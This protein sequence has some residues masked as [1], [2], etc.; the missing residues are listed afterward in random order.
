M[1]A[2][3]CFGSI[4]R[5]KKKPLSDVSRPYSENRFGSACFNWCHFVWNREHTLRKNRLAVPLSK[6][7][8]QFGHRTAPV[9]ITAEALLRSGFHA[10]VGGCTRCTYTP[11]PYKGSA[12]TVCAVAC[13][14]GSPGRA[15]TAPTPKTDRSD[16]M[17]PAFLRTRMRAGGPTTGA[18]AT[19]CYKNPARARN[20]AIHLPVYNLP[21]NLK[22]AFVIHRVIRRCV[23]VSFRLFL[24]SLWHTY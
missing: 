24:F 15:V 22:W 21:R 5:Y 10:P 8:C 19:A 3:I 14:Q 16:L 23:V 6:P 7:R 13:D 17:T 20:T 1:V 11:R 2:N 18:S 4:L 9:S 12:R